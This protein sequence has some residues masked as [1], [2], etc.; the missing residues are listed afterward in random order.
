M[1][2]VNEAGPPSDS[3]LLTCLQ[4]PCEPNWRDHGE[5]TAKSK[6]D[7]PIC[8]N[9]IAPSQVVACYIAQDFQCQSGHKTQA[10]YLMIT[11]V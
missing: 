4:D 10:A 6:R 2:F 9:A 7:R 3:D 5:S 8:T 1:N 11:I